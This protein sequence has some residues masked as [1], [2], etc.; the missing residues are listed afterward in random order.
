MSLVIAWHGKSS[1]LWRVLQSA[2]SGSLPP[3]AMAWHDGQLP[4]LRRGWMEVQEAFVVHF[5]LHIIAESTR[6]GS[7]GGDVDDLQGEGA[8]ALWEAVCA[9]RPAHHQTTFSEYVE[10]TIHQRIRRAYLKQRRRDER[11]NERTLDIAQAVQSLR[12]DDRKALAWRPSMAATSVD[13]E[14]FRKRRQRARRRLKMQF[15]QNP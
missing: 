5:W 9:F 8:L 2:W 6:Y 1:S 10:N 3:I 4:E 13:Y 14:K 11:L 15:G 7:A 12:P